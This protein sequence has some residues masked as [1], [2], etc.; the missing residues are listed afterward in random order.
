MIFLLKREGFSNI[1]CDVVDNI[2]LVANAVKL[3]K[4][5]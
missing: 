2:H 4:A 3:S 5:G 1:K